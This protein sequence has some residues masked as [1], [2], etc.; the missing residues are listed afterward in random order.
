MD[1]QLV[2]QA[3]R[4]IANAGK[5]ALALVEFAEGADGER[6]YVLQQIA[7]AILEELEVISGCVADSD[8]LKAINQPAAG[9]AMVVYL[10]D[11][12]SRDK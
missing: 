12:K 10:N 2:A 3:E 8:E 9:Q 1:T 6:K 4:A 7:W 5:S 11:P